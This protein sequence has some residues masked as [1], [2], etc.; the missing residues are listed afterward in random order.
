MKKLKPDTLAA[1]FRADVHANGAGLD[2][3]IQDA[4]QRL[5]E[6]SIPLRGTA[7]DETTT[8]TSG[9]PDP[10]GDLA[11][12]RT[13]NGDRYAQIRDRL[14]R[15]IQVHHNASVEIA[16]ICNEWAPHRAP[17]QQR[18]AANLTIWCNNHLVNGEMEPRGNDGGQHCTWCRDTKSKFGKFPNAELIKV[19]AKRGRI[20]EGTYRRLLAC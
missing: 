8:S 5:I 17:S 7:Y 19:R 14:Q 6:A 20:D 9:I 18:A 2:R 1:I 4:A 10:A 12:D 11:I 16:A 13:V 3:R 15:L